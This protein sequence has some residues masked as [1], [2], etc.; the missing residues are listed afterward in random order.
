MII[1][2]KTAIKLSNKIKTITPTKLETLNLTTVKDAIELAKMISFSDWMDATNAS[3]YWSESQMDHY[4]E[5]AYRK[6]NMKNEPILSKF[7]TAVQV[8]KE[9]E[10]I[11]QLAN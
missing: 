4:A 6:L 5:F 10:I 9:K 7:H 11:V 2:A 1:H 8:L 3:G